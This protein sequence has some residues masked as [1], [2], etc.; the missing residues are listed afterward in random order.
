MREYFGG[1]TNRVPIHKMAM[2]GLS[3]YNDIITKEAFQAGLPLIDLRVLC[4]DD[5]DFA[6]EIE[7]SAIGGKKIAVAIKQ[8][9]CSHNFSK[10]VSVVYC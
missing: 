7:P 9:V 6:N 5:A 2:I 3:I 10:N 8:I 1:K 4:N